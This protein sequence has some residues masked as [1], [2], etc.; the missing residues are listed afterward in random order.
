MTTQSLSNKI[1]N[2]STLVRKH[3]FQLKNKIIP[4]HLSEIVAT[5]PENNM[6]KCEIDLI[7]AKFLIPKKSLT[8]LN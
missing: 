3:Q 1:D 7:Q 4:G 2:K 5:E 8:K 6:L